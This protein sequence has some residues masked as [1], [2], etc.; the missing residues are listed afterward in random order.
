MMKDVQEGGESK[1]MEDS[2]A[3]D[4]NQL[5][6]QARLKRKQINLKAEEEEKKLKMMEL[7]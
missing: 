6:T 5:V 7:K 2:D 3:L 1:K 4:T